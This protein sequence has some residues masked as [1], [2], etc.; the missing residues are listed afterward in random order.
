MN[1][2]AHSFTCAL[3]PW[4]GVLEEFPERRLSQ[5]FPTA[6]TLLLAWITASVFMFVYSMAID[7]ILLCFC[8]DTAVN[9]GSPERRAAQ[10]NATHA[11]T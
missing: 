11:S 8:E 1:G 3:L 4:L 5:I 10:T 9:D 6:F 2:H 7:T